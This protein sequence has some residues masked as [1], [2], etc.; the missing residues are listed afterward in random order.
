MSSKSKYI[1]FKII[2][3]IFLLSPILGLVYLRKDVWFTQKNVVEI[4]FGAVL[5]VVV[6]FFLIKGYMKELSGIIWCLILFLITWFLKTM[7]SDA[8]LIFGVALMGL[9]LSKPFSIL[10]SKNKEIAK[11]V[12]DEYTKTVARYKAEE[13]IK[14]KEML[15]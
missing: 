9:V 4:S 11:I 14:Q 10:A 12:K 7:I 3:L 1:L 8:Y 6:I 15:K 2:E 13:E 5:C